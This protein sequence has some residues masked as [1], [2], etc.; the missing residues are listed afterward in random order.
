MTNACSFE[1]ES[2]FRIPCCHGSI[3]QGKFQPVLLS[4]FATPVQHLCFPTLLA[5]CSTESEVWIWCGRWFG[6]K[7]LCVGGKKVCGREWW[8]KRTRC[9]EELKVNQLLPIYCHSIVVGHHFIWLGAIGLQSRE[10]LAK[11]YSRFTTSTD[12]LWIENT[13]RVVKR[14]GKSLEEI[15]CIGFMTS[16]FL[17]CF[18]SSFTL[19]FVMRFFSCQF[20]WLQY[21][22]HYFHCLVSILVLCWVASPTVES[23]WSKISLHFALY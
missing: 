19:N 23:H 2:R 8:M 11:R 16:N 20:I 22:W 14:K 15:L 6:R 9:G 10:F 21:V 12:L 13:V 4:S 5:K 18:C 17:K 1:E 3:N 7:I